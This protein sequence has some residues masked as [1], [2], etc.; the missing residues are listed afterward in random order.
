[1]NTPRRYHWTQRNSTN[2][3]GSVVSRKYIA[4]AARQRGRARKRAHA[5]TR[6]AVSDT[7]RYNR[8]TVYGRPDKLDW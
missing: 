3:Q 6:P 1:M 8:R 7:L 2:K 4:T 5:A